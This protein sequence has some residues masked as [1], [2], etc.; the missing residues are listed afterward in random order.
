MIKEGYQYNVKYVKHLMTRKESPF[1]VFSIGG[2]IKNNP[3]KKYQ[4]YDCIVWNRHVNIVDGDKITI[5]KIESIETS[6]YNG[7]TKLTLVLDVDTTENL[8]NTDTTESSISIAEDDN[9]SLPFEL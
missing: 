1:T 6:E 4:Y 2:K 5:V 3:N 8:I 9:T 7:K